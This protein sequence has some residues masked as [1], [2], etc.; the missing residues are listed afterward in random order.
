MQK[1]IKTESFFMVFVLI[2]L[3]VF[4]A[5]FVET[6]AASI[7]T[8]YIEG[9]NVGVRETPSSKNENNLIERVSNISATVLEQVV[10]KVSDKN[11]ASGKDETWLKV[12]YVKDDKTKTG[13]VFYNTDYIRLVT[14]DPDASFESKLK[15]FP[16]SYRD[17]LRKLHAEY[18]NWEFIPD[19][20]ND[21]FSNAV[22]EQMKSNRKLVSLSSHPISWRSMGL[23]AYDWST[24]AWTNIEGGWTGASKEI[25]SYY[26]DPRNFLN[27][28]EIY[29][30]ME[31]SYNADVQN[32]DGVSKIIKDTFMEKKYTPASGETGKGSYLTVIMTA[33]KKSGVSPYIIASKIRQEQGVKGTSDLISGKYKGYEGYYNFFNVSATGSTSTQVIKNGL[34]Y[35]KS[36]DWDTRYKSILGG[37]EFL[38]ANYIAKGQDTYYYQDFNVHNGGTH[39]YAQAVHD[40]Y[41]KGVSLASTYKSDKDFSLSFIIPVYTNMPSTAYKMP[42]KSDKKN[43]YYLKTLKVSGLTPSFSMFTNKYDLE[44]S[45]DTAIKVAAVSGAKITSSQTV[46]LKKGDNKVQIKVKAETGSTNTYVINVSASRAC[47]LYLNSSGKIPDSNSSSSSSS[48]SSNTSSTTKVMIGDVNINGKIDIIDLAA[49]KLHLLKMEGKELKGDASVAADVNK[50]KKITIVDLA[51]VKMHLLEIKFIEQ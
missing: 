29:M 26:M 12:S 6:Y 18:P 37:A 24:N 14:Y 22:A 23:G 2:L 4:S 51:A 38:A 25:I 27:A 35:A 41:N 7:T 10:V 33:A 9:T 15:A 36:K 44:V 49:I 48:S 17:A 45:K 1:I 30:F 21:S 19:P 13:Y 16:E 42:A 28:D 11:N 3:T 20:V 32:K 50:D 46:S 8:A 40:A 43:N 31:Q 34:K 47:T 5:T 39:Q